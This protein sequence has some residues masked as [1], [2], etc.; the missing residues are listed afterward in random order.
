M[1]PQAT[2]ESARKIGHDAGLRFVYIS[3][4]APHE[5][6]H[7]YCPGCRAAVITRLG[8]KIIRNDVK[9]GACPSCRSRLP[10]I[11]A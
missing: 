9:D 10:G 11:W 3:N 5:G 6:N 1:T 7:T 2:L 8:F 4:L